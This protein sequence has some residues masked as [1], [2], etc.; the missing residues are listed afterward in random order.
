MNSRSIF[1]TITALLFFSFVFCPPAATDSG[2]VQRGSFRENG[3]P[4]A[5]LVWL[6]DSCLELWPDPAAQR[7]TWGEAVMMYGL[8]RASIITG[9]EKYTDYVVGFLDGHIDGE[10]N[11]DVLVLFPDKVAPGIAALGGLI[12]TGD[13]RY[14]AVCDHLAEWLMYEAPRADNGGWFH[15]PLLDW[16]YIDTLFMTTVFLAG[17]GSYISNDAYLAEAL[18]QHELLS[19]N[20][21]SA[22][23]DLYWHGWDQDGLLCWWATPWRRHND[24]FWGRG[25]GWA[26]ASLA[27]VLALSDPETPGYNSAARRLESHLDRLAELQD[28]IFGGWWTVIDVPQGFMNYTETSATAL[29]VEAMLFASRYGLTEPPPVALVEDGL[30]YVRN[31]LREDKL[32]RARLDGASIGTNPSGYMGYV[33]TPVFPD[34]RWGV[35]AALLLLAEAV[36]QGIE[37]VPAE[38]RVR[39]FDG[40]SPAVQDP[41]SPV[42]S[43]PED[44]PDS[45][46]GSAA[47]PG[48]LSFAD[49]SGT[50][51]PG[52]DPTG[53]GGEVAE[54]S[55]VGDGYDERVAAFL[56]MTVHGDSLG[57]PGLYTQVARMELNEGPLDP[58]V[59]ESSLDFINRRED[60]SD[61]HVAALLRMLLGYG[62]SP[63][64][65]DSLKAAIEETVLNFKY[66]IDEPGID[67]MVY[68]SENHQILYHSAEYLA[69]RLFPEQV[70]PNSG[71]TG[72]E[73]MAKAEPMIRRWLERRFYAGFSE[74]FSNV[75]YDKDFA[76][77]LNLVDFAGDPD[78]SV[79]AAMVADIMLLDMTMNSFYGVMGV[80]HGRTYAGYVTGGGRESTASVIKL[81]TGEG[82]YNSRSS[83]SGVSLAVSDYRPPGVIRTAGKQHPDEF[84]NRQRM[85]IHFDDAA[86]HGLTFEDNESGI[87]WWGMGAY[88]H[89]RIVNLTFNMIEDYNLWEN[90]F[91]APF[92]YFRPVWEMGMAPAVCWS[93]NDLTGGPV[94]SQVNT[95][96][97]R[98]PDYMLACAQSQR[99][100]QMGYQQFAWQATLGRDAVVFTSHPGSE[101]M[102]TPGYWTGGWMPRA[103]QEQNVLLAIY[104][105]RPASFLL[106]GIVLPYTH[107][108]VP[109][110]AFD[111]LVEP[112]NG[113]IFGRKGDGYFA[114][115]SS[116]PAAWTEEGEWAGRELIAEKLPA[117]WI[118]ELGRREVNGE[119]G[120]FIDA[121]SAAN[122]F[123]LGTWVSYD[124][125]SIGNVSAGMKLPFKVDGEKITIDEY[126]RYD[127]P[128]MHHEFGDN[129]LEVN[130]DSRSLLIDFETGER[131]VTN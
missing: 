80:S 93:L 38:T 4:S 121:I 118:C 98:T 19:E 65:G 126:P 50:G 36:E 46:R 109:R 42:A 12:R 96:N 113:W 53:R 107:A 52:P 35:G 59:I 31:K 1:A 97:W 22:D 94:L 24:A 37:A 115:Y 13:P 18:L 56:E 75:Y 81:A 67:S 10:G 57:G 111:E 61:F 26:A 87:F 71:L 48:G 2:D 60:C 110:D 78:I 11:L 127:N 72:A 30:A 66:W 15:F 14:R 103:L 28:P 125:P 122:V 17:Y 44:G 123:V 39:E 23:D 8:L 45:P 101:T 64:L 40:A 124:S 62:D 41:R 54:G 20:L 92:E 7:W 32:G 6:A 73:H 108:Y 95:Y 21:F 3:P 16:Q 82:R 86:E 99:P 88:V 89:W 117:V 85:G 68:W 34:R 43:F 79:R 119:F 63:L 106:P 74:W 84:L 128:Y 69:G 114:L 100:G 70:F 55:L 102:E 27:R 120:D 5:D 58:G 29:I 9:D 51:D 47:R 131:L 33:L 25:N 90:S 49:G 116:R 77:L 104:D 112:G 76:P 105:R 129:P 130:F 83:M 91:L